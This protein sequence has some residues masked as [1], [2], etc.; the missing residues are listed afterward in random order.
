M[1][2]KLLRRFRISRVKRLFASR[3]LSFRPHMPLDGFGSNLIPEAFINICWKK[4]K[5][6]V[7]ALLG[8]YAAL[9][10]SSV[11]T[12]R[13]NLFLP[14]SVVKKSKKTSWPLKMEPMG[15]SET[16]VKN[17]HSSLRNIPEERRS[18][19]HRV[20]SLKSRTIQIW[21]KSNNNIGHFTWRPMY[22]CIV[23]KHKIFHIWQSSTLFYSTYGSTI[24]RIRVVAFCGKTFI[25]FMVLAVT[26]SSETERSVTFPWQQW[27][28]ERTTM[29]RYTQVLL[30]YLL[31]NK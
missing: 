26:C 13:G 25:I 9:S 29:L 8:C 1:R 20:G 5:F 7:C 17:Y 2:R 11:P 18:H 3:G 6:E 22:V 14:S 4:C 31:G 28:C 10:A 16:S 23:E 24:Q 21:L 27:F 19:L 30:A 15:C 12:S